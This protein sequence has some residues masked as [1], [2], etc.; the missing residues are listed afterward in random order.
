MHQIWKIQCVKTN[1]TSLREY[2]FHDCFDHFL[3]SA[4]SQGWVVR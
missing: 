1:I 4:D 3:C 2:G